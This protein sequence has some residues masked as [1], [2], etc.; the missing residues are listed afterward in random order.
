MHP[1]ICTSRTECKNTDEYFMTIGVIN[2]KVEFTSSVRVDSIEQNQGYG[3][4]VNFHTIV[5]DWIDYGK[6]HCVSADIIDMILNLKD[7]TIRFMV[8]DED[9]GIA[10]KSIGQTSY[11]AVFSANEKHDSIEFISYQQIVWHW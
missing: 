4:I 8:N 9:W 2:A 11:K 1:E 5:P 6:R 10:W 7:K 3:W